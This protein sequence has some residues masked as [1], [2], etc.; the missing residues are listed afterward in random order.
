[1][2]LEYIGP[3]DEVLVPLPNGGEAYVA[4]GAHFDTDKE[5]G[6]AL[7]EQPSN[8]KLVEPKKAAKDSDSDTNDSKEH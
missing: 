5:H 3:F 1:M 7:L 6:E 2:K 8:W 4:N